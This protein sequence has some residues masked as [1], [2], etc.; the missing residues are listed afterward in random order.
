[1]A[2]EQPNAMRDQLGRGMWTD[3]HGALGLGKWGQHVGYRHS[4]QVAP[5]ISP[6]TDG[7]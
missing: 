7:A 3:D 5:K 4:C 1:M 6:P 2:P